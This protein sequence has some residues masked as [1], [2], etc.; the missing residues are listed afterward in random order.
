MQYIQGN[1]INKMKLLLVMGM[2]VILAAGCGKGGSKDVSSIEISKKGVVENR[3]IEDFDQPYYDSDELAEDVKSEISEFNSAKGSKKVKLKKLSVKSG[4]AEVVMTY[5]SSDDFAGFNQE[6]FFYGTI[7]EAKSGGMAIPDSYT[8]TDGQTYDASAKDFGE[9]HI[10]I[11]ADKA[12]IIAPYDIAFMSE[13]ASLADGS[14]NRVEISDEASTVYLIL[15][16]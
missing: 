14:S 12:D 5:S 3:I 15:D 4:R 1:G 13:G 10:V 2:T 6:T 7:D 16:K 8:A 9:R 11:S